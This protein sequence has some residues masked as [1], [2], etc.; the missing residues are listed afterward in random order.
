M[1]K[2]ILLSFTLTLM[3]LL[4]ACSSSSDLTFPTSS[5]V[6]PDE[7]DTMLPLTTTPP[8]T[9][10]TAVETLAT[11]EVIISTETADGTVD[12][13]KINGVFAEGTFMSDGFPL[14]V[15]YVTEKNSAIIDVITVGCC[16]RAARDGSDSGRCIK[17]CKCK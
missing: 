15:F 5:F 11:Y 14:R 8:D 16:I 13:W 6:T 2:I 10:P 7:T 1:K 17:Q 9:T 4:V 12:L 3:I